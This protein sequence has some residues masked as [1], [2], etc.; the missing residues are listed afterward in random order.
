VS[1]P[2]QQPAD[3]D[4]PRLAFFTLGAAFFG[5]AVLDRFVALFVGFSSLLLTIFLAWLL[6]F[7][8][9]PMVDGLVHRLRLRRGL[10]IAVSYVSVIGGIVLF[11][12]AVA[13]I[14]VR[15]A[16]DLA[17]RTGEITVRIATMVGD[18]QRGAGIDRSTIDLAAL[19]EDLQRRTLP[20]LIQGLADQTQ[21]IGEGVL[22]VSG[23]LF[24][25]VLLSLYAVADPG[26]IT[27]M[28]RRIVP[29]RHADTLLLIQRTGGRSFR[30]FLRAQFVRVGVQ[31][32]ITLV[33]G[34]AFDLPYLLLLTVSTGMLMFSPFFGP[35]LHKQGLSVTHVGPEAEGSASPK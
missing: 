30:G 13:Q 29:N 27:G 12:A 17:G 19:V 7:L 21:V 16:S 5:L 2:A 9:S 20:T 35:L 15:E 6:A 25:I 22:A 32:G 34:V 4:L 11:V 3:R 33:L 26:T 8:I 10:A 31:V 14:G 28:V 1:N 23:A 24:I 18:L